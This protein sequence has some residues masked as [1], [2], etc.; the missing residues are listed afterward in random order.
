MCIESHN[1]HLDLVLS[2]PDMGGLCLLIIQL[3]VA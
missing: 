2:R 1:L 3:L